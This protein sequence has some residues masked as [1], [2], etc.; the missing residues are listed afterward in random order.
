MALANIRKNDFLMLLEYHSV[1][2]NHDAI[3]YENANESLRSLT[4]KIHR[5]QN[6]MREVIQVSVDL[7]EHLLWCCVMLEEGGYEL[8]LD[9][10]LKA[11]TPRKHIFDK[12]F[13]VFVEVS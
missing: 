12:L 1:A 2:L 5:H 7:L 8:P 4:N 13:C 9:N 10:I 3:G 6:D 11:V